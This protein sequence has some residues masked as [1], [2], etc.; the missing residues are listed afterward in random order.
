[1]EENYKTIIMADDDED[2]R[3]FFRL[4]L[5]NISGDYK[6]LTF[7]DGASL[8][9]YLREN[10]DFKPYIILIDINMPRLDGIESLSIIRKFHSKEEVPIIMY[11]NSTNDR[12]VENAIKHGANLYI[13]KPN[14]IGKLREMIRKMISIDWNQSIDSKEFI[15]K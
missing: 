10:R 2:D 13:K 4:A 3:E 14:D 15:F 9:K 8:V 11:T 1:M 12:D 5:E 6:L 7:N